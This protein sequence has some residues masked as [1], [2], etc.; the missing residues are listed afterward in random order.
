MNSKLFVSEEIAESIDKSQFESVPKEERENSVITSTFYSKDEN[1]VSGILMKYNISSISGEGSTYRYFFKILVTEAMVA[2][3]TGLMGEFAKIKISIDGEA[4]LERDDL[5]SKT[6][7][8]FG[9]EQELMNPGS[10][11][12]I[13]YQ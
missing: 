1:C 13:A 6:I 4:I 12:T 9:I 2:D 11:I 8:E 10:I 3:F 7:V 5:M